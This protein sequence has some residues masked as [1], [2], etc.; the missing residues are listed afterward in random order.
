MKM[1]TMELVP[2]IGPRI[3]KEKAGQEDCWRKETEAVGRA[4]R[5]QK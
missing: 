3:S 4:S 5:S 2:D 1:V